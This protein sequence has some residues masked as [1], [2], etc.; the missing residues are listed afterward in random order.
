MVRCSQQFDQWLVVREVNMSTDATDYDIL[1][2]RGFDPFQVRRALALARGD[3]DKTVQLLAHNIDPDDAV[4]WTTNTDADWINHVADRNPTRAVNRALWKSP[5]Y[6]RVG[7]H[8]RQDDGTILFVLNVIMKDGRQYERLRRLS[9]FYSFHDSLPRGLLNNFVNKMPKRSLLSW[10]KTVTSIEGKRVLLEE[11]MRELCMDEVCMTNPEV[12]G[13][14][15]RFLEVEEDVEVPSEQTHAVRI[16][17]YKEDWIAIPEKSLS[18]LP[19]PFTSIAAGMPFKVRLGVLFPS[20]DEKRMIDDL[21]SSGSDTSDVQLSKDLQRD[22]IIINGRRIAGAASKKN[23]RPDKEST[24]T[25]HLRALHEVLTVA[26]E[27]ACAVLQVSGYLDSFSTECIRAMCLRAL[28]IVCRTYSAFVSHTALHKIVDLQSDPSICIVPESLLAM[29]L[30]MRFAVSTPPTTYVPPVLRC[31]VQAATVYR[32]CTGDDLKTLLQC[33]IVFCK[34]FREMAKK[35]DSP[36]S[37]QGIATKF[38]SRPIDCATPPNLCMYSYKDENHQ[39]ALPS[40]GSVRRESA[41]PSPP[42]EN[43]SPPLKYKSSVAPRALESDSDDDSAVAPVAQVPVQLKPP[44]INHSS[45]EHD[46]EAFIVVLKE[47]TTTSRDW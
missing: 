13:S 29:P 19:V 38:P 30:V 4:R 37:S 17:D 1:V 47:T 10:N 9:Q 39:K 21:L 36:Q 15:M 2:N 27:M 12:L 28:R 7:S 46:S 42:P 26:E 44:G 43:G 31:E 16:A 6:V 14:L 20:E 35:K 24:G 41:P 34:T 33:K 18:R 45:G 5:I 25:A 22:R 3:M 8:R 11:W 40:S 32:F 23:E